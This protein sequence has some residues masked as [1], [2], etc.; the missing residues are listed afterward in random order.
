MH[1]SQIQEIFL[2]LEKITGQLARLVSDAESEKETRRDRNK[3]IDRR[4]AELEKWQAKWGGALIA[5]GVIAT[6]CSVIAV[7]IRFTGK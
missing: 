2:Q 6:I 3:E 7:V 5:L 1:E 4:L